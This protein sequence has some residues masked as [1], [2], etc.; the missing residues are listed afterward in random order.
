LFLRAAPLHV[1]CEVHPDN[2]EVARKCPGS[3]IQ[4]FLPFQI[5]LLRRVIRGRED[6]LTNIMEPIDEDTALARYLVVSQV[7]AAIEAGLGKTAAIKVVAER[8][9]LSRS[10]RVRRYS[11]R[12]LWRWLADWEADGIRGLVRS[13]HLSQN[14]SLPPAFLALVEEQKQMWPEISIPEIIRI[15]RGS[16]I[17]G[18]DEPIDRTTAWRYCKRQ[19]LPTLRRKSSK[20]ERQRP[21]RYPNRMQCV[22]A[23]GKHFR[24]GST[25]AKRVAVIFLD[26]ATR[27]VLAAVV[28]TAE[29]AALAL[30]GLRKVILRWGLM[31]CLYVDLGF[32]NNDMARAAA[33]LHF[34]FILGTKKYPE[35]RGALE[36]LNRTVGEQLLCGWPNNPSIDPELLTLERR[37]EHWA[38]EQY[39]HTPHEGLA[40]DTPADRFH[41][42]T[43]PL[44]IPESQTI[45]DE[46]FVTSFTRGVKN[47]NCVSIDSVLWEVPLGHRN[48]TINIFRNMI[49][50]QLSVLHEGRRTPIKPADLTRNAYERDEVPEA[51]EHDPSSPRTTA[52]DIKWGR[53]NP[54]LVDDEGNYTGTNGSITELTKEKP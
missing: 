54:P 12:S 11:E 42:D 23:D 13:C 9:H 50:G 17:I 47:H 16:G 53:D 46:A 33:A 7:R 21:W 49:T 24:A 43:R 45:V 48:E 2:R 52:A 40:F 25:R 36:R 28:G 35:G 44:V 51:H 19:E 29:S 18:E 39:N 5:T 3:W 27:F 10:K 26:N 8:S 41:G 31:S 22:L 4:W 20:R 34:A 30:R 14:S 38:F 32:D 15:A 37:V 1:L 6:P